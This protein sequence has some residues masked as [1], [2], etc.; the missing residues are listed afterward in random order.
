MNCIRYIYHS[1]S[2]VVFCAIEFLSIKLTIHLLNAPNDYF[3][4]MGVLTCLIGNILPVILIGRFI[5]K[6]YLCYGYYD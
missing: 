2:F 6:K 5:Y 4:L 3:I 1:I